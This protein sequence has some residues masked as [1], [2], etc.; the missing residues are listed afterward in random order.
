MLAKKPLL[1]ILNPASPALDI[2]REYGV[3][4]IFDSN[5]AVPEIASFLLNL[6][7]KNFEKPEYNDAAIKKYA[8]RNMTFNQ[9]LLFDQVIDARN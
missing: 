7:H 8:A 4:D 3:K 9:C 6:A 2:L 1:V 5:S